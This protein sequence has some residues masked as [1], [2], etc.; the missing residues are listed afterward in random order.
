MLH[1]VDDAAGDGEWPRIKQALNAI[2]G[3]TLFLPAPRLQDGFPDP[4][5]TVK[6]KEKLK[7]AI[8]K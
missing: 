7:T 6:A 2:R 4:R 1:V 3:L 5:A 8:F